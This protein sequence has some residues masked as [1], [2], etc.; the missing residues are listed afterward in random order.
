MFKCIHEIEF[1]NL[2][3]DAI[4]RAFV[5]MYGE[6]LLTVDDSGEIKS[7][8]YNGVYWKKNG[9]QDREWNLTLAN[10]FHMNLNE[11]IQYMT[12]NETETDKLK[13]LYAK[14][15]RLNMLQV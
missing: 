9:H 5:D 6:D 15:T 2:T 1:P 12:D 4:A 14:K 13:Q 10:Q 7:Y 11:K 8:T 3:D